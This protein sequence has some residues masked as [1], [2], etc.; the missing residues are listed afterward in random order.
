MQID[1]RGNREA[2]FLSLTVSGLKRKGFQILRLS[3]PFKC[4]LNHAFGPPEKLSHLQVD[5]NVLFNP[6]FC[7]LPRTRDSHPLDNH[8]QRFG[9]VIPPSKPRNI[10]IS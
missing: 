4:M 8:V 1:D 9:L 10:Y 6:I 2:S 3:K 7:I 5:E